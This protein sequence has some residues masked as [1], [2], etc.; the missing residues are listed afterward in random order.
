[1]PAGSVRPVL[2][3][4]EPRPAGSISNRCRLK[5]GSEPDC[6]EAVEGKA[7]ATENSADNKASAGRNDTTTPSLIGQARRSRMATKPTQAHL[8]VPP[9]RQVSAARPAERLDV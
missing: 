7:N 6:A 2:T 5:P 4:S 1:M 3:S 9:S 8:Q